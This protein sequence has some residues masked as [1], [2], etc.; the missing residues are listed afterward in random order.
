MIRARHIADDL[1]PAGIANPVRPAPLSNT[2]QGGSAIAP[3][4]CMRWARAQGIGLGD[5]AVLMMTNSR[6]AAALRQGLAWVGART[7][8]LDPSLDADSLAGV[9]S[10]ATVAI[11][12]TVLAG[13]Y[14]ARSVAS[15][16]SPP[17]GGTGPGP[18]SPASMRRS[19]TSP[20][21]ISPPEPGMVEGRAP[22][23]R[24]AQGERR[25]SSPFD[26]PG[27]R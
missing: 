21:T 10:G 14:A 13:D 2:G 24:G 22:P 16:G 1:P 12:D 20:R 25:V 6:E 8:D 19:S 3:G 9:L 15:T 11:I 5:T 17:S 7:R 26:R 4:L 23:R 18:T 27:R